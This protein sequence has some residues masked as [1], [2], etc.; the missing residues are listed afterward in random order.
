[1]SDPQVSAWASESQRV[2]RFAR[3]ESTR[4]SQVDVERLTA[5]LRRYGVAQ[6]AETDEDEL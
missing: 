5:E 1:M 3:G 2:I 4:R 6:L